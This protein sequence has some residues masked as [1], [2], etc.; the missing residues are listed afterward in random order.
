MPNYANATIIGHLGNDPETRYTPNQTAVASFSVAVN[1]GYGEKKVVTWW[2]VSLFG[3]RAETAAKHLK[4]GAAVVI[5]GEPSIREWTDKGDNKRQSLE[6]RGN[7]WTF[8][9][10][11][12]QQP[13]AQPEAQ[14]EFDDD[15]PF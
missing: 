3:K 11:R 7:D 15:I 1:T 8:A 2:R 10:A 4:K 6:I 5:N 14:P 12:E 13:A 9:G